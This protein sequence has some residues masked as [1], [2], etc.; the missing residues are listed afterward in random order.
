MHDLESLYT[1]ISIWENNILTDEVYDVEINQPM[2]IILLLL[3]EQNVNDQFKIRFQL[4]VYT[5]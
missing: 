1:C 5:L 4:F 3:V 2:D